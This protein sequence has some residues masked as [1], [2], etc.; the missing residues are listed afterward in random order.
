MEKV[1]TRERNEIAVAVISVAIPSADET[2]QRG[3]V[4]RDEEKKS[5]DRQDNLH[6]RGAYE[7]HRVNEHARRWCVVV[8]P[9][10]SLLTH[11]HR[12]FFTLLIK[13]R[14]G[15]FVETS[16]HASSE[17][18]SERQWEQHSLPKRT[19]LCLEALSLHPRDRA[20]ASNP[21][22]LQSLF[23][24]PR[25]AFVQSEHACQRENPFPP[26]RFARDSPLPGFCRFVPML[27]TGK[28]RTDCGPI[29]R[30]PGLGHGIGRNE[31]PFAS[32]GLRFDGEAN[33]GLPF[34]QIHEPSE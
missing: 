1:E 11:A 33:H 24:T 25:T 3:P 13:L 30:L 6:G 22:A 8:G 4:S 2:D 9:R 29:L 32:T 31:D 17:G 28:D 18:C 27:A 20:K 12:Q 14:F 5:D 19:S 15:E 10:S 26:G 21:E 34:R 23:H 7:R 16:L